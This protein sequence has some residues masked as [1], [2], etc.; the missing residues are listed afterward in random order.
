MEPCAS[1]RCGEGSHSYWEHPSGACIVLS[2][3]D[4]DDARPFHER[5]LRKAR[6]QAQADRT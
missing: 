6:K 4:G 5:D 1:A 3:H 2:G